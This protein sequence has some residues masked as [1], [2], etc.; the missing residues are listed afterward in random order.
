VQSTTLS[1]GELVSNGNNYTLRV[2]A[3]GNLMFSIRTG[4]SAWKQHIVTGSN[5]KDNQWHHVAIARDTT[6]VSAYIDGALAQ[7]FD[8][9]QQISFTGGPD[10]VFG[11]HGKGDP[12]FN[13]TGQLD[14]TRIWTSPRTAAEI[15][16]NW[17]KELALPQSGLAGYWQFNQ[18]T[19]TIVNDISGNNHPLTMSAGAGWAGGFPRQ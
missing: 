15:A 1:G 3:N 2:L 4:P 5:L 14:E 11:Q 17:N 18:S 13:L 7:T 6:T 10:L 16:A 8:T 19:G 12:A 9:P